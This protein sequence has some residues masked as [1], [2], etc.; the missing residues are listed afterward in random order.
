MFRVLWVFVDGLGVPKDGGFPLVR[1]ASTLHVCGN[2]E[3]RAR[4]VATLDA[5]LGVPGLPGSAS[6]QA[7]L[8]TG[9]NAAALQGRHLHGYPGPQLRAWL[10]ARP[11]LFT[12]TAS[13]LLNR[14]RGGGPPPGRESVFRYAARQAG[15]L[16]PGPLAEGSLYADAGFVA[17]DG[18]PARGE[19]LAARLVATARASG[20]PLAVFETDLCDRAGHTRE[21]EERRTRSERAIAYLDAWLWGAAQAL[22]ADESLV[23][24]SD[25]GNV[26]EVAHRGHTRNPV[27]LWVCGSA[28]VT[29]PSAW[30]GPWDLRVVAPW[31][32]TCTDGLRGPQEAQLLR[33]ARGIEGAS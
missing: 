30:K 11:N 13:V 19:V 9:E 7:T 5:C 21:L 10:D 17:A 1:F 28:A 26:E 15:A 32:A 29:L 6:G 25:H 33:R 18:D 27:P 22:T 31:L 8:L 23:V 12:Q 24:T 2:Q 4:F 16:L 20:A 3:R 14:Y